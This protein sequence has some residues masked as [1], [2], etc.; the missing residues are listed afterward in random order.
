MKN[1][2]TFS[3]L[4]VT[5]F[6]NSQDSPNIVLIVADDLGY[7]DLSCYGSEDIK[8]PILDNMAKEGVK[9]TN[10]YANGPECSP[11]RT[12]L[13]TGRYQQRV[14]G[15]ECAI[16]LNDVGRYE[17]ALALSDRKDIG[18][19]VHFNAIPSIF[20]E[21][22]YNTALIGKWHLGGLERFR[23]NAHGFDYSIGCLGGG[24]DYFHHTEPRGVFIGIWM[25]GNHDFYRNGAPHHREGYYMTHLITDESVE[26]LNIQD[27]SK[28]FFLY[29]PYT[30]PHG[31]IQGP[32]DYLPEKITVEEWHNTKGKP[33]G[34]MIESMDAGIGKILDKLE[35]KGFAENTIVIF[36][37]DNGCAG[38]GSAGPLSGK[39]GQVFEGGIRVPCII[40]WPGKIKP[41][42][43]SDQMAISMDL[44]NS[45]S[46][47]IG[48]N[49]PRPFDG[50][51]I[52]GHIVSGE[53]DYPRTLFWRYK[54]ATTVRKALRDN[55]MKYICNIEGEEI[56]EYVFDLANDIA[57]KNNLAE[58]NKR[59][60]N[61]LRKLMTTWEADVKPERY[62]FFRKFE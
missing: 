59:E 44:T 2:L 23:P 54:R 12:A 43:V 39:K 50:I 38:V 41:G 34:A 58:T 61:R 60:L 18:L 45:F 56:N 49:P 30:A 7:G 52:I 40:K 33:Y 46:K 8:T 42:Q 31:P 53:K 32:D 25:D 28:P 27:S 26:W 9:F 1:L 55:T 24:V 36:F 29:V 16:G 20:N 4:L 6:L 57:E 51:D 10:F 13:L 35:E 17:E 19:P 21:K 48:G 14:G 11:T 37:S 47:I 3:L 5:R 62:D 15:L 22:G